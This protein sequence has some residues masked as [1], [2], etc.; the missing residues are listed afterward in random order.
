MNNDEIQ[1]KRIR[2]LDP[3]LVN[4][5][6]AGEI[7]QRPFNA[8]KELIENCLDAGS[9]SINIQIKD[10]GLKLI[11]INDNGCGIAKEDLKLVC[12]RFTTSK[13]QEFEDLNS[14][15]T[16]GFRGEALASI[17]HVAR[18]TIVSR[19]AANPCAFK[20]TYIDGQIGK[21]G[22]Q[23]CAMS[24]RGTQIIVEDLFYNCP[25]RRNALKSNSEEFTK[26]Y[27]VVSRYAMHNY[28]VCFYLKRVNENSID[29]KT[30]G[31]VN[32]GT[33]A[34]VAS[35]PPARSA[36]NER[37]LFD[38]IANIYGNLLKNQVEKLAI[39]F[40]EKYKFEVNAYM[41]TAKYFM[42]IL[43]INERLVDCQ[44][45][46]KVQRSDTFNNSDKEDRLRRRHLTFKLVTFID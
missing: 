41:A 45:L 46:K 3:Q 23:P 31:C 8:L 10:G 21:E 34:L 40:D 20:A 24:S 38:T 13:L 17:S 5:I 42:F 37:F 12:E 22:I 9:S 30:N 1:P 2:P 11:Q 6:A 25:L 16:F 36:E 44:P 19:T 15:N 14:I 29:L 39:E 35:R 27:E 7:I 43:F 18:L 32:V 28:N 33:P 26:I 4:R